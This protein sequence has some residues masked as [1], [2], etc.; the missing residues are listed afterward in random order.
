MSTVSPSAPPSTIEAG[1]A[2]PLLGFRTVSDRSRWL[3]VTELGSSPSTCGM[4]LARTPP[5]MASTPSACP[6]KARAITPESLNPPGRCLGRVHGESS[7]SARLPGRHRRIH[8]GHRPVP[9]STV[10]DTKLDQ[11]GAASGPVFRPRQVQGLHQAQGLG[12]ILAAEMGWEYSLVDANWDRMKNG[13]I[14]DLIAYA[15]D[16]GVGL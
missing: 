13:T 14:H 3:L 8:S 9:T 1:W 4:R 5:P 11:A 10:K 7:S 16:K 15:K 12:S 2:F 6:M